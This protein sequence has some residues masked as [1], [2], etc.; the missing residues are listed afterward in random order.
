[1]PLDRIIRSLI[2]WQRADGPPVPVRALTVEQAR[3]RYL[4][5]AIRSRPQDSG[6]AAAVTAVLWSQQRALRSDSQA[7]AVAEASGAE[8]EPVGV[9]A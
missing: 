4:T 6:P 1:M 8:M 9:S 2:T 3:E 5:T 7:T